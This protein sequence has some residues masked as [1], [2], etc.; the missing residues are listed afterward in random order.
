LASTP[1]RPALAIAAS[2]GGMC[3]GW[4]GRGTRQ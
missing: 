2:S 4:P 1:L 3:C